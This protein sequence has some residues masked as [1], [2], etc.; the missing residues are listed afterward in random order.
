MY[1][2]AGAHS[3]VQKRVLDPPRTG[4]TGDRELPDMGAGNQTLFLWKTSVHA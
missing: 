4:V 1:V 2:S 3:R